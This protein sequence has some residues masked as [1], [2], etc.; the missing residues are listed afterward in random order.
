MPENRGTESEADTARRLD[1]LEAIF[2]LA[3]AGGGCPA[4][5]IV[6]LERQRI[7]DNR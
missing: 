6:A 5:M 2:A 1:R 4:G 3:D 7:E